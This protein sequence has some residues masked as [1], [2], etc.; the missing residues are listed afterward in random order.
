M[1]PKKV[2]SASVQSLSRS[3]SRTIFP[4]FLRNPGPADHLPCF[5]YHEVFPAMKDCTVSDYK[6]SHQGGVPLVIYNSSDP[7]LP[8]TVFSPL[9]QPM[10]HQMAS[11]WTHGIIE[12]HG[13]FG[14][15]IKVFFDLKKKLLP[16]N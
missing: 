12:S 10:A 2:T 14:A 3:S 16:F 6:E 5:A 1:Q 8:M 7:E 4:G 13:F 15:G 9:N 11:G